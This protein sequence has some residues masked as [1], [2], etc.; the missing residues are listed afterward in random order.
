[1][2]LPSNSEHQHYVVIGKNLEKNQLIVDIE[3]ESAKNLY[4]QEFL[5]KNIIFQSPNFDI[6]DMSARPRYRDPADKISFQKLND[7]SAKVIFQTPQRA[8]AKGQI[9][10]FYQG[11]KLLGGG[12]FA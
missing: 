11:E 3:R 8:V 9:I 7:T 4:G 10:A 12:I 2:N 6:R 1:M 5:V